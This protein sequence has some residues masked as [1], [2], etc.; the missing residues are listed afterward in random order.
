VRINHTFT[1]NW[2]SARS[3]SK[4]FT[5][6]NGLVQSFAPNVPDCNTVT[7]PPTGTIPFTNALQRVEQFQSDDGNGYVIYSKTANGQRGVKLTHTCVDDMTDVMVD[8]VKNFDIYKICKD[9]CV[10]HDYHP[11]YSDGAYFIFTQGPCSGNVVEGEDPFPLFGM[12]AVLV[13]F[14]GFLLYL[15]IGFLVNWKIRH[16]ELKESFPPNRGFWLLLPF[17]VKDGTV[18]GATKI[19]QFFSYVYHLIRKDGGGYSKY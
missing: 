10:V 16:M 11:E 9:P 3:A 8:P 1:L 4:G 2:C 18:F 7:D 6:T 12:I 14:I 19:I 15:V 5:C 13:L 17:L